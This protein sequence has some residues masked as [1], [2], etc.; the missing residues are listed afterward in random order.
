MRKLSLRE[1]FETKF[2][3]EPSGCWRWTAHIGTHG[4]GEFSY[5]GQAGQLAHRISWLLYKGPIPKG[6]NILH[7]R[8]CPYKDC[9]NPDHLY[10][11]T[12][13][14]NTIDAMATGARGPQVCGSKLNRDDIVCIKKML[15]DKIPNWLIAWIYQIST[16]HVRWIQRGKC[17]PRVTI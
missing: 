9:V 12:Q 15:R 1:R 10:L 8:E 11:G 6:I 7:K 16:V 5:K 3:K 13:M 4:Y 14:E 17:W 2:V